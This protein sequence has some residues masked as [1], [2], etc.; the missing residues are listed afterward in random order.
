MPSIIIQNME[1]LIPRASPRLLANSEATVAVMVRLWA[2]EA[3]P[4]FRMLENNLVT[5]PSPNPVQTIYLLLDKWLA[6]ITDVDVVS[7]F[8]ELTGPGHIY[9]TGDQYP[10]QALYSE[11]Y[12]GP[13]TPT[14]FYPIGIV[15]PPTPPTVTIV[16]APGGSPIVRDYV[17]TYYTIMNE[18]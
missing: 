1:G 12:L 9:Y 15:G 3:Q 7:G 8:D 5:L 16:G 6:W 4:F 18:E 14:K 11:I 17:Y 13:A 10:K 2:G